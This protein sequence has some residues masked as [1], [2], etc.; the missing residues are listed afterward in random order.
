MHEER[1]WRGRNSRADR[2]KSFLSF[3]SAFAVEVLIALCLG[4]ADKALPRGAYKSHFSD[5]GEFV[6]SPK[7]ECGGFWIC[8]IWM[9]EGK[10]WWG[11]GDG[12]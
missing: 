1:E 7:F 2:E 8:V 3:F 11:I 6:T 10:K 4:G 12:E 5:F 9:R